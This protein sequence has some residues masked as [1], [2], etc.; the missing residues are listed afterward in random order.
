MAQKIITKYPLKTPTTIFILTFCILA[1]TFCLAQD[2]KKSAQLFN[3][4]MIFLRQANNKEALKFFNEAFTADSMNFDAC[5][6][7]GFVKGLNGDFEG[8]ILDYTHII[9]I[10]PEHKW[11]YISR[12][13]AFNRVGKYENAIA[14]ANKVIEID[15][16]NSEAY[17]NRGFSKKGLG[18]KEGACQD[19]NKSKKMG[20]S[21]ANIILKNNLCK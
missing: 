12:S 21:E 1:S 3:K 2:S 18:D 19:W 16:Q 9:S 4:G 5:I 15:P 20:N 6:K 7:R 13:G 8:E 14:D 10:S 11:A 17:N